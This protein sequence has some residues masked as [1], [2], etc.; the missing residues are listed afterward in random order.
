MRTSLPNKTPERQHHQSQSYFQSFSNSQR[1]NEVSDPNLFF[2][3][4]PITVERKRED[5]ETEKMILSERE[6]MM[7][8]LKEENEKLKLIVQQSRNEEE[9]V[10]KEFNLKKSKR[11]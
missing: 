3:K 10:K 11:R 5:R 8:N 6:K 1:N 2:K 9:N 4:N 7:E